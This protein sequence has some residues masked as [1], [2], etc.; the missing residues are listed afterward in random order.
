MKQNHRVSI[1][2]SAG[3][4]IHTCFTI[5]DKVSSRYKI[6][7]IITT[8][9]NVN[10]K[11]FAFLPSKNIDLEMSLQYS[12]RWTL[13][14]EG[15]RCHMYHTLLGFSAQIQARFRMNMGLLMC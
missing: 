7:V 8:R 2:F 10:V 4:V 6:F 3:L 1:V 14:G 9:K 5:R 15:V 12:Y 13:H 11:G